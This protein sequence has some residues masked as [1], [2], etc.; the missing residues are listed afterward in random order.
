VSDASSEV[1][2]YADRLVAELAAL[3]PIFAT[4]AGVPGHDH[5]LPDFSTD[6]LRQRS[7][8]AFS[9]MIAVDGLE[10]SDDVDEVAKAVMLERLSSTYALLTSG[11]IRRTFSVLSSPLSEIRQV[12]EVTD[13]SSPDALEALTAR[14]SLVPA[15]LKSWR[16]GLRDAA[17]AGDRPA[18]R[19]VLGVADQADVYSAGAFSTAAAEAA[20]AAFASGTS[21]ALMAAAA[22]A[23]AACAELA[24]WLRSELAPRATAPDGCGRARY[25]PWARAFTGA[26]LDLNELYEWGFEELLRIRRRMEA[27]VATAVPGATFAEAAAAFDADPRHRIIGTDALLHHLRSFT[28]STV[29][30]LDRVHFA[31]DPRIRFC[32]ARLAPEG[33]A[34]APY[35]IG[36][37]EDLH[38]PGTTW[39]PTLGATEFPWWRTMSTW[40][41]EGVPGHHLQCA[42]SL[43]NAERQTRFQRLVGWTSGYGEGWALY[44]ERLM[45][46]L[47]AFTEPAFEFGYLCA[48]ALRAARII[49]DL[50]LHLGLNTPDLGEL[51]GLGECSGVPWTPEIAVALLED[52]TLEPHDAA[53]SEVDRY[54]GNPGQAISYKVGE[55]CWLEVRRAAEV[56]LGASF[57]LKDFHAHALGLGPM[58]LDAFASTMETWQSTT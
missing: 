57:D 27:V 21:E 20:R 49:I 35:Y 44:A 38:R 8:H 10:A 50:G 24:T 52:W 36:P 12:I 2:A 54:L 11:E 14:L 28:A 3:D 7:E 55:R 48:Q 6:G 22:Q 53:V 17:V 33:S 13:L 19:Q 29:A 45:D 58:G 9:A 51:S 39:F 1:F 15:S 31:I 5:E 42:T 40:Y 25:E 23:D 37:S 26:E 16:S 56:R 18:L 46:E 47:G 32:D 41:H 43:I 4:T 30:S 34:A